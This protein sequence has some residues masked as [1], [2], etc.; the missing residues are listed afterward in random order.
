MVYFCQT[1]LAYLCETGREISVL[2]FST[3]ADTNWLARIIGAVTLITR[4]TRFRM[5][6]AGAFWALLIFVSQFIS[7]KSKGPKELNFANRNHRMT[8]CFTLSRGRGDLTDFGQ[9]CLVSLAVQMLYFI[10][11]IVYSN[12]AMLQ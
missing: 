9:K 6:C 11:S 2:T 12:L 3:A 10:L 5:E 7:A 8:A 1:H 4:T